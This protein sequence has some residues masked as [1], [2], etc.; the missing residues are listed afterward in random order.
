[1]DHFFTRHSASN[2][3]ATVKEPY[4]FVSSLLK[5]LSSRPLKWGHSLCPSACHS[6]PPPPHIRLELHL[7]CG[8]CL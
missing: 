1:M 7:I 5:Q 4:R 8:L 2:T 6:P 3:I